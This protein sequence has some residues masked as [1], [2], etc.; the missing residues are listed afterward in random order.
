ML[1]KHKTDDRL[2]NIDFLR[3]SAAALVI[4]QHSF[5]LSGTGQDPFVGLTGWRTSG[6]LA[7]YTFFTLSG[8]LITR[9]WLNEAG[10]LRYVWKRA[11][12]IVPGLAVAVAFSALVMGPLV[13]TLP[14]AEY[15]R[16]SAP[17]RYLANMI[18]L[19]LSYTLPGVFTQ[20]P[21]P[22]WV[23]GSLWTLP[24]EGLMYAFVA[25]A[26]LA[27][28]LRYR[29]L[30]PVL[31]LGVW[32]AEWHLGKFPAITTRLPNYFAA[33]SCLICYHYFLMGA[34][35]YLYRDRIELK[36]SYALFFLLVA[37]TAF[38]TPHVELVMRLALPYLVLWVAYVR[39][40]GLA[41]FGKLGDMSYGMYI[42]AFPIQQMVVHFANG[43][44]HWS[45]LL[46]FSF[47]LIIP[48][49]Y[50]SWHFVEAPA[51]R[52]RSLGRRPVPESISGGPPDQRHHPETCVPTTDVRVAA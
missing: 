48:V 49:A 1:L 31:L 32:A 39:I 37:V 46:C 35:F 2:N 16:H 19:P 47:L 15:F 26:G 42:Y 45:A 11:L 30:A 28:L 5:D 12:R 8:L 44:I 14:P 20:L 38:H 25:L 36:A 52:L 3:F 7:V 29:A 9:S 50:L 13:S 40:P 10:F 21:F 23:N 24:A 34:I 51:L 41:Q 33:P 6:A 27:G 4:F 22:N 17:Y 43:Q 18:L